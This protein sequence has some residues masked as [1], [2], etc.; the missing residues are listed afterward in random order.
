[1]TSSEL[2]LHPCCTHCSS[3]FGMLVLFLDVLFLKLMRLTMTLM[4]LLLSLLQSFIPV[5]VGRSTR[6]MGLQLI[7]WWWFTAGKVLCLQPV[8]V[9]IILEWSWLSSDEVPRGHSVIAYYFV[10][11]SFSSYSCQISSSVL[12]TELLFLNSSTTHNL[13][14]SIKRD[15]LSCPEHFKQP[16][17]I[18]RTMVRESPSSLTEHQHL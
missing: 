9:H 10:C 6:H 8:W 11:Q 3:A 15:I 16:G 17:T 5:N 2:C 18:H 7:R 14:Y 13:W 1:M 4:V 12:F